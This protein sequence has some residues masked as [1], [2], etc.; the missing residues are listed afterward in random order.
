MVAVS[1]S[2]SLLAERNMFIANLL[3]VTIGVAVELL[4][5][6]RIALAT[7]HRLAKE[8]KRRAEVVDAATWSA[9]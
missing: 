8:Q 5:P 2:K 7:F 1:A 9:V 4:E 6:V 3:R